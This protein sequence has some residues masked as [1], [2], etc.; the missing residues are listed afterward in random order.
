MICDF[1]ELRCSIDE[2][3]FD[4]NG[5]LCG[6]YY[7]ENGTIRERNPFVFSTIRSTDS[8][9]IPMFHSWPHRKLIEL[10]GFRCNADCSYCINS[11]V[12]GMTENKI[13]VTHVTPERLIEIAKKTGASG[14]H[15]GINEVTVNLLSAMEIAGLAKKENFLVGASTNGYMTES[16]MQLMAE[17]FDYVNISLKAFNSDY[18]KRIIGLPDVEVVKRNIR[19]LSK[20]IHVEVTTPIVEGE[21]D[22][23]IMDIA[24]FLASIDP[25]MPWHIF[26]L[27]PSYKMDKRVAPDIDRLSRRTEEAR[28]VLP[29]TYF[30][31]FIGS[32]LDNTICPDCGE[33]LI[34]RLCS[35]SCGDILSEYNLTSDNRCPRCGRK[36][37][38]FGRPCL[39]GRCPE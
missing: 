13:S 29:F 9:R 27:N 2:G 24:S 5:S 30:S 3:K 15:F 23:E 39:D 31:N 11:R 25:E 12:M 6:M 22:D 20:R 26:R 17:N 19:E 14:F 38:M 32:P 21:N 36:I 34:R 37:K 8:E 33:L 7:V 28:K 35:S 10:G 16:A 18:Y 1:C 4:N